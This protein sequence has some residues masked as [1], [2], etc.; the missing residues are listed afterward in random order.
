MEKEVVWTPVAQKDFWQITAYLNENWADT[1]LNKFSKALFL[2][3][4][5]LQKHLA[6]LFRRN[7][8]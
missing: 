4:Q 3:I 6:T 7:I 8:G 2:K 1:V 5:L